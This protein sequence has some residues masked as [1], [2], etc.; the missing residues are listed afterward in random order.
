MCG[1]FWNQKRNVT[2]ILNIEYSKDQGMEVDCK[3]ERDVHARLEPHT[4]WWGLTLFLSLFCFFF[5]SLSSSSSFSSC[6]FVSFR[7]LYLSLFLWRIGSKEKKRFQMKRPRKILNR[8]RDIENSPPVSTVA[9][10]LGKKWICSIRY[11]ISCIYVWIYM[12]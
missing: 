6:C 2:K 9:T 7:T 8:S 10:F 5:F 11:I 12:L 3:P 4:S 1:Y